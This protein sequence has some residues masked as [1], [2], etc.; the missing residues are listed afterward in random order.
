MITQGRVVHLGVRVMEGLASVMQAGKPGD[1]TSKGPE[2][3]QM[4]VGG[5]K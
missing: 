2:D 5:V 1:K 4:W 3:E